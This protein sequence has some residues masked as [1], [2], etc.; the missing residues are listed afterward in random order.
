MTG[1]DET[2][3]RCSPGHG[4]VVTLC[5]RRGPDLGLTKESHR[6]HSTFP[7]GFFQKWVKC[8]NKINLTDKHQN[9]GWGEIFIEGSIFSL[10][11]TTFLTT[12]Q[13]IG[14]RVFLCP[15]ARSKAPHQHHR[16]QTTDKTKPWKTS[17]M[18]P[19]V[20]LLFLPAWRRGIKILEPYTI[21][22]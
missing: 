18:L 11:S 21:H 2:S 20:C 15:S 22:S 13:N 19:W 10:R 17:S 3:T 7:S 12:S 16:G 8:E 6:N 9:T 4:S 14:I 5:H 1:E